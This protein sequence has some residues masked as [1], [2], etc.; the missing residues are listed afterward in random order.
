MQQSLPPDDEVPSVCH[1]DAEWS[2]RY[3][4][5]D[6]PWNLGSAH[7]ELSL[8]LQD[9]RLSPPHEGATALVPGAGWGHDAV[10]LARRGWTVTAVDFVESL[11]QRLGP[12][13]ARLSGR[14]IAADVLSLDS[15]EP[16]DLIWDHT[17]FCAIPPALR[18]K[19]GAK[20]AE[21]VKPG[22]QYAGL[23]FPVG[24]PVEAAG[25]PFG[26][27]CDALLAALGPYFRRREA[28]PV[29]R[30]LKQRKWREFWLR[31]EKIGLAPTE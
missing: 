10:A 3:A 24:K 13:L 19:W 5:D 18:L 8:R 16:F 22:G 23:V 2:A 26:M 29:T 31:A 4:A 25:P 11:E 17:F 20:A 9:G 30:P 27:D 14:F 15:A 6:T 12:Q 7:P 1:T 21:L 28:E